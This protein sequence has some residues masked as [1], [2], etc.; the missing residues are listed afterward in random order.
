MSR[1]IDGLKGGSDAGGL[2][3]DVEMASGLPSSESQVT[4]GSSRA[5]GPRPCR[6]CRRP[7]W[8]ASETYEELKCVPCYRV[9]QVTMRLRAAEGPGQPD[10]CSALGPAVAEE[11][12]LGVGVNGDFVALVATEDRDVGGGL[13]HVE[14]DMALPRR[15][16][17]PP[18]D[19][20][21]T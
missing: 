17:L 15:F 21:R 19:R 13:L 4:V 9:R 3:S 18:E 11:A 5:R 16:R 6:W 20:Y 2:T 7:W 14:A 1:W 10:T 12:G 8:R